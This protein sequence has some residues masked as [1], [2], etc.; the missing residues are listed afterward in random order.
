MKVN[1]FN[2]HIIP[3]SLDV[4][5]QE[6]NSFILSVGSNFNMSNGDTVT[7]A[8][9]QGDLI[10]YYDAIIRKIHHNFAV[11]SFDMISSRTNKRKHKRETLE[12]KVYATLSFSNGEEITVSIKDVSKFGLQ[13]E[14]KRPLPRITSDFHSTD[15]EIIAIFG[16]DARIK[17]VWRKNIGGS[18][19]YGLQR[20]MH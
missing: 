3:S 7:I 5:D 13:I 2:N 18:Y 16:R 19:L 4:L 17:V 12:R 1:V 10:Y 9:D 8:K 15:E 20:I 11:A 14:S 6:H